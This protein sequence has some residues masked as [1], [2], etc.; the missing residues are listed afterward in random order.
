[1][2]SVDTEWQAHWK[3]QNLQCLPN[4]QALQLHNR[5]EKL[6]EAVVEKDSAHSNEFLK[7]PSQTQKPLVSSRR[8]GGPL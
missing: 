6:L 4:L 3:S 5:F 1:M 7:L 8:R 2:G